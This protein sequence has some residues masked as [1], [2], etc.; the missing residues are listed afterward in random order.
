MRGLLTDLSPEEE[1]KKS[2]ALCQALAE[3][4]VF[5]R[6]P[7][8]LGFFPL[9]GEPKILPLLE[10]VLAQG[11]SLALPR[12]EGEDLIFRRLRSLEDC[13]PGYRGIMEPRGDLPPLGE[14]DFLE[15]DLLI[16]VPG[17]A[18]DGRGGRL[19]RGKG[20]YDRLLDRLS[21]CRRGRARTLGV[22]YGFQLVRHIPMDARDCPVSGLLSEGGLQELT[23]TI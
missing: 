15:E 20:F 7:L 19:G 12:V 2:R 10:R 3:T 13:L 21:L 6:A 5:Q 9:P 11:R 4:E 22:C 8:V 17:L 23:V 18:F 16:L 14:G 1:V